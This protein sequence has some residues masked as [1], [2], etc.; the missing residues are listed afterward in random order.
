MRLLTG[1]TE[2]VYLLGKVIEKYEREQDVAITKNSNRKNYDP[3]AR[4]LSDISN[5]L[6]Q[7]AAT[8]Q[9][10]V[11]APDHNPQ[12]AEYP[13]RKYDITGNQIKD[14]YFHQIVANPRSF[15]VDACYIYLFGMGRKGFEQNP[16]DENLLET[17]PIPPL[18]ILPI[19][20]PI[21]PTEPSLMWL[22][23]SNKILVA[24][25]VGLLIAS[26]FFLYKWR[27]TVSQF[28]T[29]KNDLK[30]T[31]YTPT[32]AEIDSLEGIWLCYTGSPQARLS[33]SN[34]YHLYV[35]NVVEIIYKNGYFM[36][37]RYGANFDH[38][39]YAQFVA[40]SLVSMFTYVQNKQKRL[41]SPRHT[42]LQLGK[43]KQFLSV[44]SASWSFD[45]G[46]K[47]SMIGIREVYVKQGKGGQIEEVINSLENA[48]CK[49]KII[50]W[51][52]EDGQEQI[53]QL[54]N[55]SLDLLPDTELR[56]LLDE[57]SILPRVPMKG[58]L[59][60]DSAKLQ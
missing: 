57:N 25:A 41:E 21:P 56:T 19:E 8:L 55:Q 30:I 6:P 34:R 23:R 13:F 60:K 24:M 53:F 17:A 51:Q 47:N 39:G 10:D 37:T 45:V 27:T 9:H 4:L 33:D 36:L 20:T 11:Y 32:Q 59:L 44:I 2:I 22:K 3:I 29:I 15:L 31:P 52:R 42:L 49:C 58:L 12:A 38:S 7:T 48:S 28:D 46:D 54:K 43:E 1:K 5:A 16:T 40:P 18:S 50:K 35:F 26:S 14:A